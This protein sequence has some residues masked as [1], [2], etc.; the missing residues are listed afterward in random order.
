[1]VTFKTIGGKHIV[2][3]NGEEFAFNSR[4][5]AFEFIYTKHSAQAS[6]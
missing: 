1:M 5:E 2:T 4:R 3:I 6:V